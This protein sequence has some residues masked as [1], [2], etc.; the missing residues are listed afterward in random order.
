MNDLNKISQYIDSSSET[1]FTSGLRVNFRIQSEHLSTSKKKSLRR[2]LDTAT[3]ANQS[4]L[5]C[6]KANLF[7]RYSNR[8]T[9]D[10]VISKDFE[11]CLLCVMLDKSQAACG[12]DKACGPVNPPQ[13]QS[14]PGGSN[15]RPR[16]RPKK[17]DPTISA[18]QMSS[19]SEPDPIKSKKRKGQERLNDQFQAQLA[20]DKPSS[21]LIKRKRVE[22]VRNDVESRRQHCEKCSCCSCVTHLDR[23]FQQIRQIECEKFEQKEEFVAK[24]KNLEHSIERKDETIILLKRKK[25]SDTDCVTNMRKQIEV[26]KMKERSARKRIYELERALRNVKRCMKNV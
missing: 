12:V 19:S 15:T 11:R 9:I 1:T 21:P 20:Q 18:R 13:L 17:T 2:F 4:C 8:S 6:S 14:K 25:V 16:P 3:L 5:V 24:I 23:A 26:A 7:S 10:C 22:R